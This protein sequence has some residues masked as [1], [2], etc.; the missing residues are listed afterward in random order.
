MPSSLKLSLP[1]S[2]GVIG[3]EEVKV[4]IGRYGPYVFFKGKYVS[5]PKTEDIFKVDLEK[6]AEIL[7]ARKLV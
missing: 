3:E 5:I 6:A 4:G 7:K 2:I 1:K